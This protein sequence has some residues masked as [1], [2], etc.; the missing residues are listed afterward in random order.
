MQRLPDGC[1][2]VMMLVLLRCIYCSITPDGAMAT[3][4][5][6]ILPACG[7]L[8]MLVTFEMVGYAV[9]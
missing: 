6:F 3:D 8:M 9:F 7:A 1:F 5:G 4:L 2:A